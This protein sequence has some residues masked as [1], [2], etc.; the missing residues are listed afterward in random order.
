MTTGGTPTDTGGT[1]GSAGSNEPT[2]EGGGGQGGAGEPDYACD[3]VGNAGCSA[4][5]NCSIEAEEPHCVNAGSKTQLQTCDTVSDCGA[6]LI[7][8]MSN[9]V[10]ACA[11]PADCAGIGASVTCSQT[12]T[13]AKL[14]IIGGCLKD[15]DVFAQNCPTGQTCH[16]GSC[17]TNIAELGNG[18]T[19]GTATQCT[20]GLECISD[21]GIGPACRPYCS[22]TELN[23]CGTGMTCYPL[24]GDLPDAPP[25]WGVC[26]TDV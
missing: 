20:K 16:L 26:T 5:Q 14:G 3:P 19:C 25:S 13:H 8:F 17:V 18:K 9:C 10:K 11:E 21:Q 6:G 1:P 12:F 7:C 23:P 2:V 24:N 15:C 22:T 4:T